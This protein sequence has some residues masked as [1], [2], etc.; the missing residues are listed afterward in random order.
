[1]DLLV[2]LDVP[3][4]QATEAFDTQAF[5]LKVTRR[6]GA[7]AVELTGWPARLYLLHKPAGSPGAGGAP[8]R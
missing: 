4:L 8:R 5:G 2:N 1:V 6:F 7:G 3:D